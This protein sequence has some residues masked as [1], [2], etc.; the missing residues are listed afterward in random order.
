MACRTNLEDPYHPIVFIRI[1]IR[2]LKG[3]SGNG[4]AHKEFILYP[5]PNNN[6]GLC[7]VAMA[8]ALALEDGI[9]AHVT[10][11][12]Q[13]F[14]PAI[15]P[16]DHH[17]LSLRPSDQ[18]AV[19]S[20]V[21]TRANGKLPQ[22]SEPGLYPVTGYCARRGASNRFSGE[23]SEQDLRTLMGHSKKSEV[24]DS[25]YKSRLII[26]DLGAILHDRPANEQQLTAGEAAAN[27]SSRR[28]VNAPQKLPLE[29][30]AQLSAEEDLVAMRNARKELTEQ[31]T[32]L[33]K[34][35]K[36]ADEDEAVQNLVTSQISDL[37][38]RIQS[39]DKEYR[40]IVTRDQV[41]CCPSSKGLYSWR[42][43]TP[44]TWH[45]PRKQ[46]TKGKESR[47]LQQSAGLRILSMVTVDKNEYRGVY[48]NVA[49]GRRRGWDGSDL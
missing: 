2:R 33:S 20:D 16:T 29:A 27:M 34:T 47:T 45:R 8:T 11:A 40:N 17:I 42:F 30:Q 23:L 14:N 37:K 38:A 6:R 44:I 48:A 39:H 25:A 18:C 46:P 31:I 10:T 13:I 21:L 9:F 49:G 36:S 12:E 1:L 5:E 28:D 3:F 22:L 4:A 15:P 43:R 26:K 7:P 41:S 32:A 24:F 35:L 19:R